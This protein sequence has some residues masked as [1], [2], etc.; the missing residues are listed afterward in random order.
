ML[1][2]NLKNTYKK[3][4]HYFS[5][6]TI[7]L[8][9]TFGSINS[10]YAGSVTITNSLVIVED[11]GAG[12]QE[13]D[14]V[15]VATGALSG[16][17]LVTAADATTVSASIDANDVS[18]AGGVNI[19]DITATS[20]A[21]GVTTLTIIDSGSANSVLTITGKIVAGAAGDTDDT[22]SFD[23]TTGSMTVTEEVTET[24]S[25]NT[26]DFDISASQILTFT[27]NVTVNG[28]IDGATSG[29]GTLVLTNGTGTTLTDAIGA[30][31]S[32]LAVTIDDNDAATFNS[33]VSATTINSTGSGTYKGDV[34]GAM[35]LNDNVAT[36]SVTTTDTTLT[37]SIAEKTGG[38]DGSQID[39]VNGADAAIIKTTVTGT[40]AADRMD[41]GTS[42]KAGLATF[43]SAVTVPDI[44][45]TGGDAAAEDSVLEIQADLTAATSV[46]LD[47]NTGDTKL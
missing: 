15:A 25:T 22:L 35:L 47:D 23:L 13:A 44:N 26:I 28:V 37:G 4:I 9:T 46:V 1:E 18:G 21:A 29:V 7:I 36:F 43:Q 20:S 6:F 2:I 32:L 24:A 41:V 42:A 45:V 33:S 3:L 40:V 34:T 11:D 27:G 16:D 39:F 19:H 8:G 12:G 30:D 5:I 10:A 14:E 31:A 17:S 38:A